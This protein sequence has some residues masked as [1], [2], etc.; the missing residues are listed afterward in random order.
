MRVIS[1]FRAL[2]AII[3][4]LL[5]SAQPAFASVT[6]FKVSERKTVIHKTSFK[7][8]SAHTSPR[9]DWRN[10][11]TEFA[12]DVPDSA[13][14]EDLELMI[15]GMPYGRIDPEKPLSIRFN[16]APPI[17]L[18]P[19]P[20]QFDA[21]VTLDRAYTR[22]RGN[23]IRFSYGSNRS[24]ECASPSDGA[25]DLDF[26][27]SFIV[28]KSKTTARAMQIRNLRTMI[29]SSTLGPKKVTITAKGPNSVKMKALAAQ[30]I[31]LNM[32]SVPVFQADRK[33]TDMEIV[34]AKRQYLQELITDDYA[35]RETGPRMVVSQGL[36]LQIVLTGDNDAELLDMV[37]AFANY[38]M[39]AVRRRVASAGE[40]YFRTPFAMSR[41]KLAGR[42]ALGEVGPLKFSDGWGAHP[43]VLTFDVPD[44]AISHGKT[45]IRYSVGSSVH[46]GSTVTVS[47]NG[48]ILGQTQLSA[49]RKSVE[50]DIPRGLLQGIGN[51]LVISPDLTPAVSEGHCGLMQNIP[52]FSI[53]ASSYIDIQTDRHAAMTDLSRFAASGF[54]FADDFAKDTHI[55]LTGSNRADFD[56]GLRVIGQ[57]A[58]AS[59]SAWTKAEF[60]Q[61]NSAIESDRNIIL[62][63]PSGTGFE[64]LIDQAPR[65]FR[66][67]I[68]RG[69]GHRNVYRRTAALETA[70]VNLLSVR[71][72]GAHR[73]KGGVVTIYTSP[74]QRRTVGVVT[75]MPGQSFSR[76]VDYLIREKHWNRMEGSVAKWDRNDILMTQ[77]ALP[78]SYYQT[79]NPK[80]PVETVRWT[81][82]AFKGPELK[83]P[84]F[85][86][87]FWFDTGLYLSQRSDEIH[88]FWDQVRFGDVYPAKKG[89]EAR[90]RPQF[91]L[92]EFR[93]PK[94]ERRSNSAISPAPVIVPMETAPGI[95]QLRRTQMIDPV[96]TTGKPATGQ[97][98]A[99]YSGSAPALQLRGM[100]SGPS[101][102]VPVRKAS[103]TSEWQQAISRTLSGWQQ[104]THGFLKERL[105]VS[106]DNANLTFWAAILSIFLITASLVS[107]KQRS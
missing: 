17:V 105:A 94:W 26:E 68:N 60:S 3:I 6:G 63:G 38:D 27:S 52:G 32:D 37:E 23:K 41:N 36:P 85:L 88:E 98:I 42:M 5:L 19:G 34:I 104:K 91:K 96:F 8:V 70:P 31:T 18:E 46:P 45:V 53:E 102:D 84:E 51:E 74:D 14:I 81:M 86:D 78:A 11:S 87:Q 2:A 62:I 54:P 48:R 50:Y 40:F 22:T 4:G 55:R 15:S 97:S 24:N 49:R 1:E 35:L 57:L 7:N 33:N 20:H 89:A 90:P 28:I 95:P 9:L 72:Q 61:G 10:P 16:N 103:K 83:S 59:R 44:P 80:A 82:P 64:N 76:S 29:K 12:F 75:T 79:Y 99:A 43:Q 56:A 21:R 13:W 101:H 67:A 71:E 77:T 30:G 47:L 107:P 25:W 92:P 65:S 39:P 106:G 100:Q 73:I 69:N 93:L 58:L 66:T